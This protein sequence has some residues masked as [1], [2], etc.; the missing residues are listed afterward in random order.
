MRADLDG[1][2]SLGSKLKT[3]EDISKEYKNTFKRDDQG[4]N[5]QR[6]SNNHE[7]QIILRCP[8]ALLKPLRQKLLLHQLPT[9][10]EP[11][12][13]GPDVGRE[14]HQPSRGQIHN[15]LGANEELRRIS[16]FFCT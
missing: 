14:L 8:A 11:T 7:H 6:Y 1:H 12:G 10:G 2:S 5:T 4:N 9:F 13:L 16:W 3:S 15:G